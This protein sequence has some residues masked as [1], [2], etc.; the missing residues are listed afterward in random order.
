[1]TFIAAAAA[2]ADNDVWLFGAQGAW[3]YNGRA[4]TRESKTAL[5][6]GSVLAANNVWAAG[7]ASVYHW[8]GARWTATSLAR[9]LPARSMFTDP[10]VT[11]VLALS[12]DN[13]YAIGNGRTQD[14]GGPT[15][16]LHFNGR[17]WSKV[18]SGNS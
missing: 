18:A 14:A 17:S 4:W 10:A 13:V 8:N 16:V 12:A 3:H 11:S 7:G 9:L 15:V 2:A 1:V 5:D 6:A